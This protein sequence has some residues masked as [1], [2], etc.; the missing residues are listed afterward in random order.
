MAAPGRWVAPV[1]FATWSLACV[2]LLATRRYSAFI[3]PEFGLLL[4]LAHFATM[5]LAIAAVVAGEPVASDRSGPLRAAI[6]LLPI[7]FLLLMSPGTLGSKAFQTRFAGPSLVVDTGQAASH[8]GRPDLRIEWKPGT[9]EGDKADPQALSEQ[10]L[11]ELYL[12]PMR[13]DG[14]PVFV[15]GMLMRDPRLKPYFEGRETAVY[16]FLITCCAADALPLAVAVD[17]ERAAGLAVDQWIAVKGTF[18]LR[19]TPGETV[20]LIENARI[21]AT[22]APP[23][24]YLF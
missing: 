18:R 23:Q 7:M 4:V 16:R 5:G 6:L 8:S 1:V 3:R 15:T 10:T 20:P 2:Y 13:Y 19:Q 12:D 17:P 24:P 14:R 11:L 22:A 9:D 21:E